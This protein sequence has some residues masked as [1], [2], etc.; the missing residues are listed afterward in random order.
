ME[1]VSVSAHLSTLEMQKTTFLL[2]ISNL[3]V[4]LVA[5]RSKE[6]GSR[7]DGCKTDFRGHKIVKTKV[8]N[9]Y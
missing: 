2:G 8:F 9:I 4:H 1:T 3:F 5:L 6:Q 7:P